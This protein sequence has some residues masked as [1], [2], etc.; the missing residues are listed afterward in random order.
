MPRFPHLL[1][2]D[3]NLWAD[4]LSQ[5]S[6]NF[7]YFEYD[8]HVGQGRD[9]GPAFDANIR[10]MAITLSQR[11]IDVVAHTPNIVWIIEVSTTA[12]LTALGQLLAYPALYASMFPQPWPVL[13]LLVCRQLAT[14]AKIPFDRAGIPY[15]LVPSTPPQPSQGGITL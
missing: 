10:K 1:P 4:F 15:I 2:A 12:G 14:D 7:T 5:T 6:I 9:P 8:I 11:R 3:A 13:P